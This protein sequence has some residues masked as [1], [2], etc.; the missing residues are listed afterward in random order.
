[1]GKCVGKYKR[2]VSVDESIVK[3][4][5]YDKFGNIISESAQKV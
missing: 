1:M 2:V 5:A 3:R 4:A